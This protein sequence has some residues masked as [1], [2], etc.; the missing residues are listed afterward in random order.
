M[1]VNKFLLGACA[2]AIGSIATPAPVYAGSSLDVDQIIEKLQ[3]TP[4]ATRP[5]IKTRGLKLRSITQP[6]DSASTGDAAPSPGQARLRGILKRVKTRA[7][8]FGAPIVKT[9]KVEREEIQE[10]IQTERLPEIDIEIFFEY[11]SADISSQSR[12][13]MGVLGRALSSAK[14]TSANFM[15]I[16]H[17]D[18]RGSDGYNL[19][20]SE[21]RAQ[22]VRNFLVEV[23]GLNGQRFVAIG[24]GEEQLK[25]PGQPNAA[26][27]R[28]VQIVNL[29][30]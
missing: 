19:R 12:P 18:A 14:L 5:K 29:A 24:Y 25:T 9:T 8:A 11:D 16:G 30:K 6:A 20:L 10:I 15:I 22:A 3:S 27:N 21:K 1:Q 2:I 23:F 28:R 13:D 7:P 17:T 4:T 26:V